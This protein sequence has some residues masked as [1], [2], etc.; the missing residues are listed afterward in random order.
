MRKSNL[1]KLFIVGLILLFI[2]FFG[3]TA[4]ADTQDDYAPILYFEG[5]E[6]YYPVSVEY[7]LANS[8]LS[9]ITVD[10]EIMGGGNLQ[11]Y[12]AN[13][14][15]LSDYQNKLKSNDPSVSPVVY[16][17]VDTSSG[18]TVIQY[19]MFYV[20]NPGE[21]NKHEGDWEMVEIVV[22][23]A[24]QNWV[25]YSQHYS[26]QKATWDLVERD[27][28]NFKVFVARGSHANYLRSYS[29]KLGIAS[30]SVGDNGKVLKPSDYALVELSSQDWLNFDGLWGQVDSI[31]D[32]FMGE[33]GPQ[34][35]KY[36]TDMSG[37]TMWDG[38]SWGSGLMQANVMFFQIEWF[39][40]NF[41]TIL[42]II[43]LL[44]LSLTCFK[45]YR[46]HK[47]YGLGPR[48]LS[49][50]YID[51]PNLHTIGNILCFVGIILAIIGIFGTWYTVSASIN[52][53]VYQT[54]GMT[55]IIVLN[56]ANGMQIYMPTQHGPAPMGSV[57]FPF[58]YVLLIGFFF[59]VLSTIGIYKSHKLGLKYIFKGI[60]LIVVILVIIIAL[61]LINN[62][63]G[64]TPSNNSGSDNFIV[65]LLSQISSNPTGGS[66]STQDAFSGVNGYIS[67]EWGLGIG[68]F[69]LIISGIIF[70]VA[71]VLLIVD[72]K[73]FFQPKI[74]EKQ[75]IK[76][77]KTAVQPVVDKTENKQEPATGVCPN[78]GKELEKDAK[79]C[80]NCGKKT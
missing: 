56:G 69:Y 67:F 60:R 49:M 12:D 62:L 78:C 79:F 46:R 65:D 70:L 51:G 35:P 15:M 76:E 4:S 23:N 17:H 63:A 66:Y 9:N 33:A 41:V 14:D 71:G 44:S 24:G 75:K 28:N 20:F 40:Y 47:K 32:F 48:I 72:K 7:Y 16:Y 59:M 38:V 19:W 27:G 21:H 3:I 37:N 36:R 43:T 1:M 73:E 64:I 68:A 31:E 53:D 13:A 54:P 25:G 26:G 55:E 57:V 61:M 22:P 42:I 45:I 39:L 6:T 5:E 29:G 50:L 74:P 58:A 34:G 80:T 11:F 77:K 8:V 18:N 2:P 52:T 30:D 10:E